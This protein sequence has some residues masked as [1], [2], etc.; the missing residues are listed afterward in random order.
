M[1][2]LKSMVNSAEGPSGFLGGGMVNKMKES[3]MFKDIMGGGPRAP[4]MPQSM[5]GGA[6]NPS[7]FMSGGNYDI[8]KMMGMGPGGGMK[9]PNMEM[10]KMP[11]MTSLNNQGMDVFN[12]GAGGGE[13]MGGGMK[14]MPEVPS[15]N[16][17][18]GGGAGTGAGNPAMQGLQ[19][20]LK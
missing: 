15:L 5:G 17:L 3:P 6:F 16:S 14:G 12:R 20:K 18:A 11:D 10:P 4:Q 9:M 19:S 8:N 7:N 13:F 1:S 2:D